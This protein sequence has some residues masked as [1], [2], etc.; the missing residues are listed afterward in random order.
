MMSLP[1][2]PVAFR[3]CRHRGVGGTCPEARPTTHPFPAAIDTAARGW[4]C[5]MLRSA[6]T[7]I[8]VL[9]IVG[10]GA[11]TALVGRSPRRRCRVSRMS[12]RTADVP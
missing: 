4:V 9:L 2:A 1:T 12:R 6:L 10:V 8:G 7:A 5:G 11:V 3:A